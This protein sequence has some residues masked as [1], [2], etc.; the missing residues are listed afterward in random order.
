V[1][2]FLTIHLFLIARD[3]DIVCAASIAALS[4][5]MISAA[6]INLLTDYTF[7]SVCGFSLAC[8]N[9]LKKERVFCLVRFETYSEI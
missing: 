5:L 2:I 9:L 1:N 7:W 4:V 3:R 6:F 8:I